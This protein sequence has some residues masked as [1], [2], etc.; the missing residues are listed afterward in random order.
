LSQRVQ[1]HNQH[2]VSRIEPVQLVIVVF[3]PELVALYYCDGMKGDT[4]TLL[5]NLLLKL[6]EYYSNPINGLDETMGK[7]IHN[8]FMSRWSAFHL[9]IH[10]AAFATDKQ[11]CRREMDEGIKKELWSVMEDF[12]KAPGGK[13]FSKMK[14][15]Y[16]MFVDAVVSKQ[17]CVSIICMTL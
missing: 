8:V 14:P 1:N 6:D 2:R 7:K 4:V 10:S 3:K 13:D 15:Q 16:V 12:S 9:P 17:V 11:F 5:Y